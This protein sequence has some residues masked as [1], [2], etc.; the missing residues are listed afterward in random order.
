M[1]VHI[2]AVLGQQEAGAAVR[3]RTDVGSAVVVW[4][5]PPT[6]AGQQHYVEWTVDDDIAW[7]RNAWPS[8][9]STPEVREEG[10][11][12][13]FRGRLYVTEDGAA[14]LTLHDSQILFDLAVPAPPPEAH[15]SWVEIRA[16]RNCVSLWPYEL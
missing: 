13:V 16:P 12:I 2:D 5:G 14:V 3:V 15:G 6:T 11:D 1:Q 10:E 4:R 9:S 7:L 8:P